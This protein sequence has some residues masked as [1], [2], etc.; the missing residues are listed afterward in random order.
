MIIY[1]HF[2]EYITRVIKYTDKDIDQESVNNKN[3]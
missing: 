2:S 1:L 3:F